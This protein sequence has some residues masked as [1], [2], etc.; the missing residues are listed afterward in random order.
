MVEQLGQYFLLI[1]IISVSFFSHNLQNRYDTY[2]AVSGTFYRYGDG[3][4]VNV[5]T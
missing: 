4:Y 5:R 1:F 3:G 2:W